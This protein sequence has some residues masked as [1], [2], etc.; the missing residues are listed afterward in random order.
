MMMLLLLL[1]LLLL[2]YCQVMLQAAVMLLGSTGHW[3]QNIPPLPLSVPLCSRIVM[4]AAVAAAIGGMAEPADDATM[5]VYL[6]AD[7]L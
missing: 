5:V 2:Y 1:L 7:V 3:S 4:R 6:R